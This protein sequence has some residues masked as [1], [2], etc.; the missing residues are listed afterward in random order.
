MAKQ[1]ITFSSVTHAM[2][3]KTVLRSHGIYTEMVK[4]SQT[5]TQR[6]CG[7]RLLLDKNVQK[8]LTVIKSHGIPLTDSGSQ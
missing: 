4:I 3:A 7:Y 2:K 6:G 8:A 5:K 1:Y